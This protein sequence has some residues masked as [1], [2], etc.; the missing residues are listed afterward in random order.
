MTLGDI[1]DRNAR[2]FPKKEAFVF[3]EK[4]ITYRQFR[5][6]V[7]RLTNSLLALGIKK[8]DRI[9]ILMENRL[10]YPELYF[11]CAK[12]GF[13]AVPLN[14]RLMG[15]ELSYIIN[16]AQASILIFEEN[17]LKVVE[18]IR[19]E[20][21]SVK[22]Y[23]GIGGNFSEGIINYEDLLEKGVSEE[24]DQE[25][26]EEDVV[27]IFY[28]SGTTG[29][30][31]GV[32]HTH[33]NLLF[34]ANEI[35]LVQRLTP[36][37]ITLHVTPFFHIAPVWPMLTHLYMG[38]GNVILNRFDPQKVLET[39][40][41][42]R[43]TNCNLV[44]TMIIELLNFPRLKDYDLSSLHTIM[45][46]GSPMPR[47]VLEKAIKTFGNIFFQFYGLTEAVPVTYLPKEDHV[48][49]ENE[50]RRKR[51][52]SCGRETPNVWARVVNER[53]EDVRPGEVGEIIVRKNGN[54]M[55]G[56]WK[57]EEATRE[58]IRDEW[59]YTGDLATIDEEGYIYIVDRKKDMIISG[60]E[61]I[62]PREIEE[63]IYTH[64]AVAEVAVIGV[65][66]EKWGETPKAIV[67]LKDGMEATE[68]EIIQLCK[69][70]LASYKKPTSVEFVD[71]LPR[72]SIGKIAKRELKERYWKG[73]SRKV[74]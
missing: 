72:T 25:V 73:Y 1:L 16:N 6:K 70:N 12:G 71:S 15:R 43:I 39:I 41:K 69:D 57:D 46:A 56:Y 10:E 33:R 26:E 20:L 58:A 68:E 32:M 47:A 40:Q 67:M 18:S 59:L 5:E 22:N 24:P 65:P 52:D 62:Y 61:N 23:V 27:A 42:E 14:W 44:V 51:L 36:N 35:S 49:E 19:H 4:R 13:L 63:I 7:L 55:K 48:L 38:G 30:P 34:W 50:E 45:Y 74:H 28:T 11:V 17:Y 29:R 9:A 60:G 8:G 54:V 66:H 53:G 37:D 64:P 21:N 3:Q 31:K 2:R